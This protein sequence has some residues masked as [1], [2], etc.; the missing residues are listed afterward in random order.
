MGH[1]LAQF[2]VQRLST[3]LAYHLHNRFG[4]SMVAYLD[5]WLIFDTASI[6]TDN[7]LQKL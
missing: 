1:P 3:A 2:I 7:I 4:I 6:P 5:D